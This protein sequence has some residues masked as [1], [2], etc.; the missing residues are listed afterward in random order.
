MTNYPDIT[1]GDIAAMNAKVAEAARRERAARIP[2]P[3][4]PIQLQLNNSGSWKTV[5][6]YDA[7]CEF[8]VDHAYRAVSALTAINPNSTWRI[9]TD[10]SHPLVLRRW[11]SE[12]GWRDA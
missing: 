1:E 11:D 8:D 4:K 2:T 12:H 3:S 7:G 9:A 6:R 10:E 5:A